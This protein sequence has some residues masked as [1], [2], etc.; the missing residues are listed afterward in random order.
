MNQAS[1]VRKINPKKLLYS[2]WTAVAPINKEKHFMI[3]ELEFDEEGVVIHCLIEAI[4][5]KRSEAID[6]ASLKDQSQWKQGWK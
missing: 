1:A 2:K 3:T 6:W 4:M 5:S